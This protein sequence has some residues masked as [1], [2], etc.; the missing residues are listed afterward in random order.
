M[1]NRHTNRKNMERATRRAAQSDEQVAITLTHCG[2]PLARVLL[3][4]DR[5][6]VDV[7]PRG[8]LVDG[9]PDQSLNVTCLPPCR[10]DGVFSHDLL[11]RLVEQ[12]KA[13]GVNRLDL[14][15]RSVEQRTI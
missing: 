1:S 11:T 8:Q 4:A 14:D 6:T 2:R 10:Y 5:L 12:V 15:A 7:H 13:A 9:E 3:V